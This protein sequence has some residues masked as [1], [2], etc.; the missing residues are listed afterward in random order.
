MISFRERL[1]LIP[2]SEIKRQVTKI[3]KISYLHYT[4]QNLNLYSFDQTIAFQI[5]LVTFG[6]EETKTHA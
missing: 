1:I 2:S 4:F 3:L 6:D 5:C